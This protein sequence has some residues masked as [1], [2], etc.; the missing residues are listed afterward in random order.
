MA[1]NT[2]S[3]RGRAPG[4]FLPTRTVREAVKRQ[5]PVR[6]TPIKRFDR[7]DMMERDL[8]R[9]RAEARARLL[10]NGFDIPAFLMPKPKTETNPEDNED[11]YDPAHDLDVQ[12]PALIGPKPTPLIS[13]AN[14]ASAKQERGQGAEKVK[15]RRH[16]HVQN[17]PGG[18]MSMFLPQDE[19]Q[20]LQSS[21]GGPAA[22]R[23]DP[24]VGADAH[25]AAQKAAIAKE[26]TAYEEYIDSLDGGRTL[27]D[28]ARGEDDGAGHSKNDISGRVDD[29]KEADARKSRIDLPDN[30]SNW[31][32]Q[33]DFA[34]K[35]KAI[36]EKQGRAAGGRSGKDQKGSGRS[37]SWNKAVAR[38]AAYVITAVAVVYVLILTVNEFSLIIGK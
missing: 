16:V 7:K 6:E 9:Y 1:E 24:T 8:E 29:L 27:L 28:H 38:F 17:K 32:S 34:A 18:L 37:K 35:R 36:L 15:P 2:P 23:Q 21:Q 19:Q 5:K 31:A 13:N 30:D 3:R 20:A 33:E 14:L 25:A 22:Q 12:P 4:R 11:E 10:K 26:K